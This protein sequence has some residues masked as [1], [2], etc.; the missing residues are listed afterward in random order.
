M[1]SADRLPLR[2]AS[3]SAVLD[4][5][6]D[7]AAFRADDVIDALGM[8][9]STALS[10]LDALIDVGLIVEPAATGS[11]TTQRLGRPARRFMLQDE[12]GLI[13][14]IDAGAWTF[15]AVLADLKGGVLAREQLALSDPFDLDQRDPGERRAAAFA[16]IDAVLSA[17]GRDRGDV[18]A[19]GVGVPAPVDAGG[20]SP[21]NPS[22]FWR[23]MNADLHGA[24]AEVFPVVRVENDA[25]L[26]ALVEGAL[27]AARGRRHF[28]AMLS[29]RRLGSGVF[30]DGR[31]VRGAHGGVGELEA[32]AYVPGVGG[33]WGMG[34]LAEKWVR[35]ALDSGRIPAGHP[36]SRLTDAGVTAETILADARL[37]DPVA[38]P[39]LEELGVTLGRICSVVSRFYDPEVI[40]VCGA[41]A[42][43]LG[44]VID[45]A[46]AHLADE[47]ELRPPAVV[48]SGFGGDVVSLGAVSAAREA[49]RGTVLQLF[50]ERRSTA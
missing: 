29:G 40:V 14:G 30:L 2:R 1:E 43:A 3:T 35:A 17:A 20:E 22:G 39:M 19:V 6:W 42:G 41:V 48:A 34:D 32:L 21:S 49:A 25:A 18:I 36:W 15:T 16:V 9:R 10:A 37:S 24:L 5:A 38:R 46:A 28:V 23:F 7:A 33:T 31:L 47:L 12:A 45:L 11:M 26:A 4:F 44:E 50:A 8:T 27:G 13:V